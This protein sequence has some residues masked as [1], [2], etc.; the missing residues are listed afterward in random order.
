MLVTVGA[1]RYACLVDGVIGRDHVLVQS[2][3][4]LLCANPWV[5]GVVV[6]ALAAPTLVLDMRAL[7]SEASNAPA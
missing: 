7:E 6:D 5:L 1:A 3:G 2:P 4:P